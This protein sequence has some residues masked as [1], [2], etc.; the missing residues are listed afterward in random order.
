MLEKF[1]FSDTRQVR[2]TLLISSFIGLAFEKL[3]IYSTGSIKFLGFKI[4]VEKADFIPEL[5]GYLIIYL[6]I[7]L[8][9]RYSDE[10]LKKG[11]S[12]SRNTLSSTRKVMTH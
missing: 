4:P 10:D 8:I 6:L 9:I 11:M 5:I 1:E 2:K 3:S 12:D 7:A